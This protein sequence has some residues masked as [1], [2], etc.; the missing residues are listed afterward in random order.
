MSLYR[1]FFLFV[2]GV[3][4]SYSAL[5]Q[6]DAFIIKI[7]TDLP[8][9]TNNTSFEIPINPSL[10]YK[11]DVDLNNDGVY[12]DTGVTTD[13]THDFGAVGE[14]IVRIK[15][16]FPSIHFNDGGDAQKLIEIRQWG[17]Q[18]WTTFNSSF[19]GCSNLTLRAIDIPDL[20]N[21]SS[22]T[23]MF[24]GASIFNGDIGGWDV[25]DVGIMIGTFQD[26]DLFDADISSWNITG[27]N[28]INSMFRNAK[29]FNQDISGWS[30]S[31]LTEIRKVFE[32]ASVFDQD[33][34]NWDVSSAIDLT[35]IFD[36]SGL[37]RK[38]YDRTL[39]GWASLPSVQPLVDVGALN[40]KYCNGHH[41]RAMLTQSPFEW[42]IIGDEE[43][44]REAE[45]IT[46]WETTSSSTSIG[47][48]T[49]ISYDYNYD[50]DWNNDGVY[51]NVGVTGDI[52]LDFGSAGTQTIRIKGQFP[53]FGISPT[54]QT[55]ITSVDQ[56]GE[57]NWLDM[58]LMF[59]NSSLSSI[60]ALDVPDLSNVR[61]MFGMFKDASSFN[62]N[63]DH[64][65]VSN[66]ERMSE[67]FKGATLFNQEL[68]DWDVSNVSSMSQMFRDASNFNQPLDSWDVSNVTSM[69][70]MFRS[71]TS[72]NQNINAW[73]AKTSNVTNMNLMFQEATSFN[74]PLNSWDVSGVIILS[75]VFNGA[76][77]FNQPLNSWDVSS[78]IALSTMFSGA[79][80]F[81]QPLDN[82]N[83]A[84]VRFM[85][86][87][88]FNASSF[89]QSLG[90]WDFL[91][92]ESLFTAFNNSAID[93][94][95]YDATLNKLGS[96]EN[97][98]VNVPVGAEGLKYC[99]GAQARQSLIDE[100]WSFSGDMLD[101]TGACHVDNTWI[102]PDVGTWDTPGS[103]S[104]GIIPEGCD[105]VIIPS[106]KTVSV[107][108]LIEAVCSTITVE[109]GAVLYTN[110]NATLTCEPD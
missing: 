12:D 30:V 76:S 24:K 110:T 83:V 96:L 14:Y 11:Y 10:T 48:V 72:F 62:A 38:N 58:S 59:Y 42:N 91:S 39:I 16:T 27:C 75:G 95:N 64:W 68:N 50:I 8:G 60:D 46:T 23:Q 45:F 92:V 57:I 32:D 99:E 34:G 2:I 109:L 19:E 28:S 52:S 93:V 44:C 88:F 90:S 33:L 61:S 36:N 41:A 37:S 21:V 18:V 87:L 49:S 56:W 108:S 20:S 69:I 35:G 54:S 9:V 40:V 100:G 3:F 31:H 25:S 4:T 13:I 26:T 55:L 7:R 103:W 1:P 82:W 70:S 85:D 74:Q 15:G 105:H 66:I 94:Q 86:G 107:P 81:N 29:A 5:A 22:M 65:D 106:G 71:A 104:K 77:S 17:T 101:C 97:P 67:M 80:S 53:T 89:N 79:S 98:Q 63:I 43:D 47:F 84:G 102:G 51:D 73:G 6:A 78:A